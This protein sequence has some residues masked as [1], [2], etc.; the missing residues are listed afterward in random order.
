MDWQAVWDSRSLLI[1]GVFLTLELAAV[2]ICLGSVVG[3]VA[4]L[5]RT[6]RLA[7]VNWA[8]QGYIGLFRG[9]P[10]LMQLFFIY[11]GLPY[12]GVNVDRAVAAIVALT[13]YSG[14]YIA[15]IVR[16]G[17]ESVAKGQRDAAQSLGL[18]FVQVMRHVVI[19]QA[20]LVTLPPLVGFYISVVKDTSL[21]YVIGYSELLRNAQSIIDRTARPM[22]VYLVVGLLYFAICFPLSRMVARLEKRVMATR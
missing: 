2:A 1:E 22:E 20:G 19:P 15:E 16:A 7:V 10:L 5:A 17:I 14:A 8:A 9:T 21:A 6:S 11:F 18:S 13:L 12:L 4:A 3:L